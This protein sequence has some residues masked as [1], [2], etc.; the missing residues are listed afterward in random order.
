[1]TDYAEYRRRRQQLVGDEMKDEIIEQLKVAV[2][3]GNSR[4][5]RKWARETLKK[6]ID[7]NIAMDKGLAEGIK[8]IGDRFER[9]E[10][11]LPEMVLAADAMNAALRI[12][13]PAILIAKK[14]K[15]K[16]PKKIV[17][18]TIK[19]D[20][21]DIGKSIVATML[22]VAGFKVYDIG[23]DVTPHFFIRKAE[24]LGADIIA[25]SALLSTVQ[26]Y[27][28][29]LFSLLKEA[30]LRQKYKIIVGG[31]CV[32][33]EWAKSIGAD[34]YGKDAYEAIDAVRSFIR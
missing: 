4:K 26:P 21:H 9:L 19:G 30:G 22:K 25:V 3:E 32:T 34:G 20:I 11:Y 27:I 29:D 28:E 7:P 6:S 5:A 14:T 8:I 2:I 1:M 10:V 13:E 31:G 23:V 15:P 17:I 33:A 18:G 24:N 12:L 16:I